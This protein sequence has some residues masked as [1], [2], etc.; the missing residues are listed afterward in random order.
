M[1]PVA[2]SPSVCG[3]CAVQSHESQ[4]QLTFRWVKSRGQLKLSQAVPH[5]IKVTASL[6]VLTRSQVRPRVPVPDVASPDL[7]EAESEAESEAAAEAEPEAA[8]EIEHVPDSDLTEFQHKCIAGY[9]K[10]PY[11]SDELKLPHLTKL[12]GLWWSNTDKFT[13]N[14]I[15]LLGLVQPLRK[16]H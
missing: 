11:F 16:S 13:K 4:Q 7:A 9:A 2:G 8:T 1:L 6:A 14:D 15:I 10:D 5:D 3:C 12:Q